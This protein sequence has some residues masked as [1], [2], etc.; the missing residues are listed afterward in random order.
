[1]SVDINAIQSRA[2]A[3]T[4]GP[5]LPRRK[6]RAMTEIEKAIKVIEETLRD[7]GTHIYD[8]EEY[9]ASMDGK[10]R[11]ALELSSF[12]LREQLE[13]QRGWIPVS[14]RLPEDEDFVIVNS[15]HYGVTTLGLY[16]K[17]EKRWEDGEQYF[18]EGDISHWMP[19]PE[20]PSG[21][22]LEG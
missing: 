19:L 3:A 10:L 16:N 5:C 15:K 17:K 14:E 11:D 22:K 12:A 1:M 21:R 18:D 4:P 6:E 9:G 2:E 20:P 8:G 13:R 7:E